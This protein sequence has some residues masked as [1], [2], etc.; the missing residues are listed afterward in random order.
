MATLCQEGNHCFQTP[1]TDT[2][3]FDM[4][5][6]Y[7]KLLMPVSHLSLTPC[8]WH[9]RS[10]FCE[11]ADTVRARP[12][13]LEHTQ[14]RL[15]LK[16]PMKSCSCHC[17]LE[18]NYLFSCRCTKLV[19]EVPQKSVRA[20]YATLESMWADNLS[21]AGSKVQATKI[22]FSHWP[23]GCPGVSLSPHF[24]THQCMFKCSPVLIF[25]H[26]W[27]AYIVGGREFNW[28]RGGGGN[29]GAG[30]QGWGMGGI[31]RVPKFRHMVTNG[32]QLFHRL[33]WGGCSNFYL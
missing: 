3:Y 14:S 7:E 20:A 31:Y 22:P 2:M 25:L 6:L 11:E 21:S 1:A 28:T 29:G 30:R 17:A 9:R 27:W 19:F 5:Y 8:V 26:V 32:T 13:Q 24:F 23:V 10:R 12:C 33:W 4:I 16:R 15:F 18:K